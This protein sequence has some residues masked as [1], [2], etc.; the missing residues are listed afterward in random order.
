MSAGPV[1]VARGVGKRFPGVQAL[2]R[3]D[4]TLFP[5][6]IL[7]VVGENGAGKSTLMKV[8]AGIVAPDAG[9]IELGGEPVDI[10]ST[11]HARELGIAL[12]HQELSL[13]DNL[14]A[15]ANVCLGCEP[16]KH[17]F[18]DH[19]AIR[20]R[21]RAALA[22][23]GADYSPDVLVGSLAI[24]Q[25]Q[26]VEIAKALSQDA[27]ILILD[28]PT[29]S[30]SLAE[31][32]HL[33]AVLRTLRAK[34]V[35]I[36][37]VSHR[38]GEV[39]AL[40]DR[41]IVLRDGRNSGELARGEI[42]R[43]AMVR[44]M[45]GRDVVIERSAST[46]C[47]GEPVLRVA[48]LRTA[49]HSGESVSLAVERGEI[50]GIAGLVGAGRTELLCAIFGVDRPLAGE[51]WV[52][53]KRLAAGRPQ[54]SIRAGIG[55]VPEDRQRH[56][57][58][59]ELALQANIGF[60]ALAQ[61][62]RHG[63]A[64][65]RGEAGLAREMMSALSIR[66][67]SP[68]QIVGVLSGGNQQKVVLA[69]WLATRPRLLLLDEPTRG[70]DV[71]ARQEIYAILRKLASGGVAILFASSEME[72]VLTL[73]DRTLVMH[74][75]GIAGELAHDELTEEAVMQLATGSARVGVTP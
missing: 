17:G 28:E 36:V 32:E 47:G 10:G 1:L 63:F 42:S 72:E 2:D 57:L 16:R 39:E 4:L 55:F 71:A 14:S 38:L 50:V 5:G 58:F 6:E 69:K 52:A 45:V 18:I 21:S 51:V 41:V 70:I 66:A 48:G 27:K 40:V 11:R 65:A 8:L 25:Q 59:L 3:V 35:S 53:G 56:G 26:G 64:D 13:A 34:G 15:G 7:A 73:S 30:L 43:D 75:G 31:S 20:E 24:G 61:N 74:A 49:A 29:S 44:L 46:A 37:Y 12:I 60:A 54:D 22:R 62:A 9:V 33:F 19:R 23:I 68:E 67:S